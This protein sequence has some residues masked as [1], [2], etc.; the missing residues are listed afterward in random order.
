MIPRHSALLPA[1]LSARRAARPGAQP[2]LLLAAL[3]AASALSPAC[4][5]EPPKE[6]TTTQLPPIEGSLPPE[7]QAELEAELALYSD[8]ATPYNRE[9]EEAQ[10]EAALARDG[11]PTERALAL[12]QTDMKAGISALDAI[13]APYA[14][15][16]AAFLRRMT[17][18][19][20]PAEAEAAEA[21]LLREFDRSATIGAIRR[22]PPLTPGQ[23]ALALRFVLEVHR[24]TDL[25]CWMAE[26]FPDA[27]FEGFGPYYGSSRDGIGRSCAPDLD[28]AW[29]AQIEAALLEAAGPQSERCGTIRF[30]LA[31][32]LSAELHRL[33][34][35][36][37]HAAAE[38]NARA[39]YQQSLAQFCE[40]ALVEPLACAKLAADL[41]PPAAW[42][43]TAERA[44][45]QKGLSAQ[46]AKR[47]VA[48]TALGVQW[49]SVEI[50]SSCSHERQDAHGAQQ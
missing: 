5:D 48:N 46:E 23:A 49:L 27:W 6:A 50:E 19:L 34:V 16:L 39:V 22:G 18:T 20:P 30:A 32:A 29:A 17:P 15:A 12:A 8:S 33:E 45:Q 42:V 26:R 3:L 13:D 43:A 37:R 4:R 44:A 2:P 28:P 21:A 1:R 41:A 10:R 40:I 36:P 35:Q 14:R 7:M 47:A 9:L 31:A 25:P 38:A 24:T 11:A